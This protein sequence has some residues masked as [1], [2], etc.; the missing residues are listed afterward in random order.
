MKNNTVN[1]IILAAGEGTR[2][3]PYT[4]DCPKCMVQIDGKSLIDRQLS[5]L[6]HDGIKD[7][8]VIGGYKIEM[9]EGKGDR[10]KE[11]PRYF[12]TNMVHTLFCAEDELKGDVVVS[13]GDIVYSHQILECLLASK[14]DISVVIDKDWEIYWRAR[15]DNPLDD[16]ETLQLR[17]D[18]TILELGQ[19]PKSVEEIQGQY[20]GLMKFSSRGVEQIKSVFNAAKISGKLLNR[21][22]DDAYMTD[23][24]QAAINSGVE[25][26]SVA[27]NGGWV[28]VD[29]VEDMKSSITS[30]RL[31]MMKVSSE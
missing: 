1:V 12:E 3:R 13:Y 4:L 29:T 7:I 11:N 15:N 5:V 19:K 20:I 18:G 2:L 26:T 27:V 8:V 9:L 28:E 31:Q 24:L 16:A 25:V 10:L 22:V 6:D 23:L 17:D 21:P 30:N 14:A